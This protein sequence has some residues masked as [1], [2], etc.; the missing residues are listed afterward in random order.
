MSDVDQFREE[1]HFREVERAMLYVDEAAR[2]CEEAV[3]T[4]R[5]DG[6]APH[7]ITALETAAGS[8]RADH[9]HLIKSVYWKAPMQL[10]QSQLVVA[11]EDQ[12][13]AS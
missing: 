10:G 7:L 8:L 3:K 11:D 13:S 12:R 9:K 4:L 2:K 6:A 1:E 5:R